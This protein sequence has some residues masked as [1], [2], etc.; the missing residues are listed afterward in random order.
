VRSRILPA[1][2]GGTAHGLA[3]NLISKPVEFSVFNPFS[4]WILNI[5]QTAWT[6]GN[7]ALNWNISASAP[8][9]MWITGSISGNWFLGNPD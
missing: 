4:S 3:G 8:G 6:T 1:I 7:V 5:P 2:R 9:S